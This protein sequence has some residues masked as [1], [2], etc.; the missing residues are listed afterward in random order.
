MKH[1]WLLLLAAGLLMNG[2]ATTS[3]SGTATEAAE[4]ETEKPLTIGMTKE[5]VIALYG[6]TDQIAKSARGE[7]WTYHHNAGQQFIPYNFG[8]RPNITTITFDNEGKL[9]DYTRTK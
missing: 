5:Q 4:V 7:V 1:G 9:V 6:T 8:Y 2:C 3:D